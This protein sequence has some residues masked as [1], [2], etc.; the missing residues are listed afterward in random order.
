[1]LHAN[2]A[3]QI[4]DKMRSCGLGRAEA[5]PLQLNGQKLRQPWAVGRTPIQGSLGRDGQVP[6]EGCPL[7]QVYWGNRAKRTSPG[8][9]LAAE[10]FLERGE[11]CVCA[12][13]LHGHLH[14][15]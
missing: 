7:V 5:R 1:V 12:E 3:T 14:G 9:L 10:D 11:V 8:H 13:L 2:A 6:S 15:H 4:Q